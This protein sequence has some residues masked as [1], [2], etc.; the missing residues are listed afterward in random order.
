LVVAKVRDR[1][2]VSK[3]MVKKMDL[4]RFNLKQLNEEEVKEQYQIK[5]KNKFASLENLDDNKDI[6]S[7]WD[8]IRQ[9]INEIGLCELKSHKPWFDEEC[10]KL[11]DQRKQAKVQ[12]LQDLS[13]VNEDNSSN[14]RREA[15]RHFKNKKREYLRDKINE[16]ESNSKNRNVR[17]FIGT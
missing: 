8:T 11:V 6:N 17:D 4:E 15:S 5:I 9:N 16:L 12:W 13:E 1:L 3:R 14:V 10:L 2:A 7:A